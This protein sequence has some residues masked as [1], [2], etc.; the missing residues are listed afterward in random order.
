MKTEIGVATLVMGVF[1]AIISMVSSDVPYG[2]SHA[3]LVW[4]ELRGTL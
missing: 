2:V 3:S 1:L 4:Q